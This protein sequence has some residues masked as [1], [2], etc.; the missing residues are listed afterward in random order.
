MQQHVAVRVRLAA[1]VVLQLH[2]ADDEL[3]ALGRKK[4]GGGDEIM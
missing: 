1:A 2:A 3:V 4:G